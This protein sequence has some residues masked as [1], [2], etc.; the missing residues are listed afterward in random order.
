VNVELDYYDWV[1][2]EVWT[3]SNGEEDRVNLTLKVGGKPANYD[4]LPE[5]A[6]GGLDIWLHA[7]ERE[8]A[9]QAEVHKDVL[10]NAL[11][12]VPTNPEAFPWQGRTIDEA[13]AKA[14]ATVSVPDA[15]SWMNADQAHGWASG[16][17]RAVADVCRWLEDNHASDVVWAVRKAFA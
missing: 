9:T 16:Y 11:K 1:V 14:E 2:T 10:V 13:I 4:C 6:A 7:R 15:P 3:V 5:S 12:D 8:E 17:E